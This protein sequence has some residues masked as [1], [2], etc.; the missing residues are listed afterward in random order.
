MPGY[1]AAPPPC[2]VLSA[3]GLHGPPVP[4][5]GGQGTAWRA[6]DAVLKPAQADS[7]LRWQGDLLARLDRRDDLRVSPPLRTRTGRWSA[8]GWG[9]WRYE[10]GA[11]EPGRWLYRAVTEVLAEPAERRTAE[12]TEPYRPAIELALRLARG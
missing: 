11:H 5:S 7:F 3:F 8:E 1:Q 9:A 10:P 6:G 12:L 4:L 2:T